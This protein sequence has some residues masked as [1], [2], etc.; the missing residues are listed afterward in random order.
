MPALREL[1]T[2]ILR[3]H[4]DKDASTPMLFVAELAR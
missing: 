3:W 2:R 1:L 4:E